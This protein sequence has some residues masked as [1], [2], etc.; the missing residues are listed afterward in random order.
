M[1]IRCG[2]TVMIVWLIAASTVFA[3]QTNIDNAFQEANTRFS[4]RGKPIHPGLVQ[5][6][7]SWISDSGAPTTISV[8]VLAEHDNEYPEEDVRVRK[9][10]SVMLQ[11]SGEQEF[12]YYR[13]LGVLH[14]GIHVLTVGDGVP[15]SGIFEDLFFVRF[16]S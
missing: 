8:D 2:L 15:G 12:F 6:F 14:N 13:W 11:K 3:A 5:E 1:K 4:F 9:D 16:V 10:G 7:C